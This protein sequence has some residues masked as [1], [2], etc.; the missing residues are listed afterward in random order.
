MRFVAILVISLFGS[1]CAAQSLDKA[2]VFTAAQIHS[3]FAALV[4]NS[5][6]TGSGGITLGDYGS[7]QIK[8]SQRTVSGG[9][10]MH[11]H[12]DDIIIVEQG[13][14][15]LITGGTLM[16]AHVAASGETTGSDIRNGTTQLISAGDVVHIPA[17]QPHRLVIAPGTTFQALV[18]K[19]KE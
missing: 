11:E 19:V 7:H 13:G 1:S 6:V 8:L 14:A 5:R 17:G 3:Q 9:A 4:S 12:F 15:S 18:I 16:N 2:E 10:E